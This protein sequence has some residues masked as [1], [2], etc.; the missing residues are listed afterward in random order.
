[1]RLGSIS[2]PGG[3][4]NACLQRAAKGEFTKDKAH[5]IQAERAAK[6]KDAAAKAQKEIERSAEAAR[7]ADPVYAEAIN[8]SRNS[9]MSKIRKVGVK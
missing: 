1:M 6:A 5:R 7:L 8:A 2:S 3:W 9:L 4:V